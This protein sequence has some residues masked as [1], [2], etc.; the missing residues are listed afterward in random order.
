MITVEETPFNAESPLEELCRILTPTESFFV[1]SHFDLP[2]LDSSRYRLWVGGEV[3]STLE[4]PLSEIQA[5]PV[6]EVTA[7]LECAGNGRI[8]LEPPVPGVRW[9]FGAAGTARFMGTSLRHV[10]DRAGVLGSAVEALFV[11]ADQGEVEPG[12]TVAF[13]R[14]L[15]IPVAFDDDSILAWEMNGEPL[16]AAHGA[17]L[18]LVVPRWYAVASVKWL[19]RIRLLTHPFVG[20]FQ[21]EKYVYDLEKGTPDGTPV[22]WMRVR[23]LITRPVHGEVLSR[24]LVEIAGMAWS[25]SGPIRKVEVSVDGG[26]HFR[27]AHLDG[28]P[29]EHAWTP[30]HF[31]WSAAPAGSHRIVARATDAAGNVQPAAQSWNAQGYGNNEVHHVQVRIE[32]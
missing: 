3:H 10:L 27:E 32:E 29:S 7:T 4:L 13:E 1:R 14:S 5:L 17:P 31:V 23:S 8:R 2:E 24:G 11:G 28:P 25:G 30:W 9:A 19:T 12:R 16:N 18:R 26:V 15:P 6:R 20:H 21:T 22:T